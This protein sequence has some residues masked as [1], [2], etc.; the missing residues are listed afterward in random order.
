MIPTLLAIILAVLVIMSVLPG[1]DGREFS[2]YG[3]GDVLDTVL[4]KTHLHDTVAGKYLRYVYDLFT[5]L[6]FGG[7]RIGGLPLKDY[8]F[9]RVGY[10]LLLTVLGFL[11]TV[12]LGVPAGIFSAL[13]HNRW[14]D[15]CTGLITLLFSSLPS[16]CLAMF[17]SL[18]F[19]VVLN[20]LP[21]FGIER[22][23]NYV[24][25]TLVIA[26]GGTA[27]TV[28]MTRTAVMEVMDKPY[29]TAM[30]ARGLGE[31]LIVR[32][33]IVK[34]AAVEI[35]ST[36][37]NLIMQILCSTVVVENF[38]SFP[39]IGKVIVS[40]VGERSQHV[41]LGCVVVMAV[42]L[43]SFHIIT[44]LICALINPRIRAQYS[45]KRRRKGDGENA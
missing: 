4:E 22:P 20:I 13:H 12:I 28:R 35:A 36:L 14:Q 29:I 37:N 15:R 43:M 34:N 2:S 41:V 16:Y 26:G 10:T 24:L 33:H 32:R 40:S 30:R 9:Q 1:S 38:Y 5:K 17:L 3:D 6:D 31:S 44:D 19:C 39:G 21:A 27:L 23:I 25:P 8:L 7:K 18:F 42:V 11:L 45:A